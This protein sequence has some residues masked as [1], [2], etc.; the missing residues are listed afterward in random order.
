VTTAIQGTIGYLDPMY[1]YTGRL[2]DKSDVFSYGVLLIELLTRKKPF[3]YR[4]DAGDGIV[5]YFVSLLAQGR[6]LEIMDPQV[7]DEEDGEI[8]EVAALAAMCTKL[9]GEDRPTMREVEM[10]LENL[11]VKKKHVPC[12]TSLRDEEIVAR[13]MSN[14]QVS[15]ETSS[16][17]YTME[18]DT[19]L[20][21]R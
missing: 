16:R 12:D 21:G 20:S 9:K 8:Q 14:E 11:L 15:T 7:I 13:W 3:A 17:Q 4:S 18:E 1:Y 6:L 19:L 2:T 5:S 10:T